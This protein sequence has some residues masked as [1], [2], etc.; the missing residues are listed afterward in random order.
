MGQKRGDQR[1]IELVDIQLARFRPGPLDREL[2]QQAERQAIRGDRV[3]AGAALGDQ[4]VCE[5]SL[6][7]RGERAHLTPP[8]LS[9]TLLAASAISSGEADK[10]QY[11][12]AGLT[13][14]R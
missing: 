1:R 11:V 8:N 3:L 7:R 13:C 14:P 2:K 5:I 4:P 10:Y 12:S 9:W 6:H